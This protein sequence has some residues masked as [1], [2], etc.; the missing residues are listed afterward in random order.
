MITAWRLVKKKY[1][2]AVLSGEGSSKNPGRWNSFGVPLVCAC[3]NPSLAVL[4]VRVHAG[5]EA[6][7][8][9][10]ALFKIEIPKA[11]VTAIDESKLPPDWKSNPPPVSTQII[12]SEWA[13]SNGSAVLIVP[14][15]LVP[16]DFNF[17]F[18]PLHPDFNKIRVKSNQDFYLDSRLW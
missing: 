13:R 9:T 6:E 12:G 14:S 1:A 4:E 8:L 16:E 3:S 15:V 2:D 11:L 10:Y 18:N 7:G 17:L 5:P